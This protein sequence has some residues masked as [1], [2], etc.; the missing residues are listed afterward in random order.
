MQ[1]Q[2]NGDIDVSIVSHNAGAKGKEKQDIVQCR[3]SYQ[4]MQMEGQGD[5]RAARRYGVLITQCRG[6]VVPG[7][8]RRTGAVKVDKTWVFSCPDRFI[9]V[10]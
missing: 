1:S 6:K 5:T 3:S 7:G 2:G 9:F 4:S 10:W 8:K